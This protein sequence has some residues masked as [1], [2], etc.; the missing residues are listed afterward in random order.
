MKNILPIL[1]IL[2]P[3]SIFGQVQIDDSRSF[4]NGGGADPWI[5][6]YTVADN[7]NRALV[8]GFSVEAHNGSAAID[9]VENIRFA[10]RYFSK[11]A[12]GGVA[13]SSAQNENDLWVL[14]D[15][16]SGTHNLR[17]DYENVTVLLTSQV[18]VYSIY[19]AEQA[20]PSVAQM[21]SAANS[22]S[23]ISLTLSGV[24]EGSI[25]IDQVVSG[26]NNLSF[27]A[28]S[29]QIRYYDFQGGNQRAVGGIIY[30]QDDG[31]YSL[32]YTV[33]A[34]TSRQSLVALAIAQAGD[35]YSS[36]SVWSQNGD[37]AHYDQGNVG[38][39]LSSPQYNLDV[40]GTI[41]AEEVRVELVNGPDYVFDADYDLKSLREVKDFI[42]VN[43]HLPGIPSALQMNE[44]G[45]GLSEM[46]KL[47]L[48]KIEELTLHTIKQEEVINELLDRVK[49][50]E[51]K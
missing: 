7:S 21:V 1:T 17:V 48:E 9:N 27:A 23:P 40:G 38:I 36:S 31:N 41:R 25:L 16:P 50:L 8:L 19:N 47:L 29:G 28:N 45:I 3:L 12:N 18:Y 34:N 11:V 13:N 33:E 42:E 39:G 10:G 30:A 5:N 15:P 49:Q 6:S 24:R 22:S 37:D 20:V 14:I 44:R 35:L 4:F 51:K 26:D 43:Q 46:N 2:F 32:S